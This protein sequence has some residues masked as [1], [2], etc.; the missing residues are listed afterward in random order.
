LREEIEQLALDRGVG[1]DLD[2]HIAAQR[3]RARPARSLPMGARDG[4]AGRA[5]GEDVAREAIFEHRLGDDRHESHSGDR[6]RR[7][8]HA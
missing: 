2:P 8:A 3:A 4:V 1:H 5:A 7:R 6:R